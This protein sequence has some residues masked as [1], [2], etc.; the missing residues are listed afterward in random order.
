VDEESYE[1]FGFSELR[2]TGGEVEMSEE[3][4]PKALRRKYEAWIVANSES[5]RSAFGLG[6]G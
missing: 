4:V 1:V 6:L 5:S 3:W 2:G